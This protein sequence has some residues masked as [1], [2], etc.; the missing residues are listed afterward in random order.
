[1][2]GIRH[3]AGLPVDDRPAAVGLGEHRVHPPAHGDPVDL[4]LERHL[5]LVRLALRPRAGAETPPAA[6]PA[7]IVRRGTL[8]G[9][10]GQFVDVEQLRGPEPLLQPGVEGRTAPGGG[11]GGSGSGRRSRRASTPG[12]LGELDEPGSPTAARVVRPPGR[13]AAAAR[14]ASSTSTSAVQPSGSSV[15]RSVGSVERRAPRV[16][17]TPPVLARP[18]P[19]SSP[20]PS[21][22]ACP[23][24]DPQ[25]GRRATSRSGLGGERVVFVG[26][27]RLRP[28]P[29]RGPPG[30][31]HVADLAEKRRRAPRPVAAVAPPVPGHSSTVLGPGDANVEQPPLLDEPPLLEAS[32]EWIASAST[33]SFGPRP[34]EAS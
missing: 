13:L 6:A 29:R 23:A 10:A 11:F 15:S 31:L 21:A 12:S 28:V 8:V 22:P 24:A 4:R 14:S 34:A 7:P 3:R 25:A 19:P 9:R 18:L 2:G 1:M 20:R 16:P 30:R 5:D 27:R 32:S 33:T 26:V 17:P